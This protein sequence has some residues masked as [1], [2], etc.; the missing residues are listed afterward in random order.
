MGPRPI[1]RKDPP[2][3]HQHHEEIVSDSNVSFATNIEVLSVNSKNSGDPLEE[4]EEPQQI[5]EYRSITYDTTLMAPISD[6]AGPFQLM[7]NDIKLKLEQSR[8]R[9]TSTYVA[10]YKSE[11]LIHE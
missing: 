10:P 8:T 4:R 7:M 1:Y 3:A 11:G 6:D 9:A 5:A 2:A